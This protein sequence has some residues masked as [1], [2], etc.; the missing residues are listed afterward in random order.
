MPPLR[1]ICCDAIIM[2]PRSPANINFDEPDATPP[3]RLPYC[4]FD[5]TYCPLRVI[6]T[7]RHATSPLRRG[8]RHAYVYLRQNMMLR[9]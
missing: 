2:P 5:A 4:R 8:C 7:P 6:N 1:R 3:R 9:R